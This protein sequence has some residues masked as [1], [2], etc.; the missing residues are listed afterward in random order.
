MERKTL[1][2]KTPGSDLYAIDFTPRGAARTT[3]YVYAVNRIDASNF[4]ISHKIWGRQ[5]SVVP[6]TSNLLK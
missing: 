2:A 3:V 4:L 5:H 6:H 1:N